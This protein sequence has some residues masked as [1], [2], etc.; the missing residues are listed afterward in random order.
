MHQFTGI[1]DE[2]GNPLAAQ[3]KATK[4]LG[5]RHIEMRN[6]QM[7]GFPNGNIH[8][9]PEEAF[10]Q[11]VTELEA[12]DIC[13]CGFGSTIGNWASKITDSFS[14]TLERVARAIPRMQQLGTQL[15]RV[16]SY[17]VEKDA[18]G[19]DLPD[20]HAEERFRRLRE[21]K[22]RF[23]DAGLTMVH[24][25]CMNYGG[26]SISRAL[27]TLEKVPGL[28]WVFDTC[29]PVFNLDR[30]N[31]P[32]MQDSWAFYQAVKPAISHIHIKDGKY[33]A[34][35][36]DCDYTLPGEGEGQVRRIL[37]DLLGSGYDGFISIEPHTAVV[38]HNT[39]DAGG[40]DPEAKAQQQFESYVA[41]GRKL[42]EM[43]KQIQA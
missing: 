27:E 10:E 11:L 42:E 33:N 16:M 1:G 35:K 22:A 28:R 38:F 15:V 23:D 8:D 29:N 41:Y 32:H 21:L 13:V 36:K 5:W 37:T 20:Q 34:V 31:P 19:H 24:E 39:G 6:V 14:I 43:V 12:E 26:M 3:I 40:M 4:A 18:S 25:N 30:D 17:A 2:A 9:I 7:P